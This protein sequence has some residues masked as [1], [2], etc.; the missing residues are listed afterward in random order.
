M[1]AECKAGTVSILNHVPS[2]RLRERSISMKKA[3]RNVLLG[4]SIAAIAAEAEAQSHNFVIP[5]VETASSGYELDGKLTDKVWEKAALISDFVPAGFSGKTPPASPVKNRTSVKVFYDVDAIYLGFTCFDRNIG[6]IIPG[7]PAGQTVDVPIAGNDD[8]LEILLFQ[9]GSDKKYYHLRIVP[10]GAK[11]DALNLLLE[12]GKFQRDNT[13]NGNWQVRTSKDDKA[14]YAEVKIPFEMFAQSEEGFLSATPVKGD[15]MKMNL[16]RVC[17]TSAEV[18]TWIPGPHGFHSKFA[19]CEFAGMPYGDIRVEQE[20][21]QR[22]KN[23]RNIYRF[24]VENTASR[25]ARLRITANLTEDELDPEKRREMLRKRSWQRPVR[26]TKVL[27]RIFD[28]GAGAKIP[29]TLEFDLLQGGKKTLDI[30]IDWLR[31]KHNICRA[32]AVSTIYDIREGLKKNTEKM[33]SLEA[34]LKD[35]S[36]KHLKIDTDVAKQ[37]LEAGNLL[38]RASRANES[39]ESAV[40][41]LRRAEALLKAIDFQISTRVRP[42]L[43]NLAQG[44]GNALF[45]IGT[46][47][48]G[49]KVFRDLPF[50]GK[51]T[52]GV[53]LNLAGNEYE[54]A[55]FVIFYLQG[56]KEKIKV[57]CSVL[58]NDSG[59]VIRRDQITFNPVG[60]VNIGDSGHHT[61]IGYWP[62]VLYQGNE[63]SPPQKGNVQPLMLTVKTDS[64]QAPGLYQGKVLFDNGRDVHEMKLNVRVY[65]FSLPDAKSLGMNIWFHGTRIQTFYG[66]FTPAR[67]G[68]IMSVMGRYHIAAG[69]RDNR[70]RA[71]LRVRK[72]NG[73]YEFDFSRMTPYYDAAVKNHANVLN[74][75]Y[76]D[77]EYFRTPR[78]ILIDQNGKLTDFLPEDPLSA[79]N[80]LFRQTIAYFKEKGYYKYAVLQVSDEPWSREKQEYIR[81]TVSRF[82]KLEKELPPIISAGAVRNRSNLN[83]Y[84]TAWCPQFPQF[85]PSDYRDMPKNE[86]LYFYQ[87]LYKPDFPMFMID[88]PGIEPRIASLICWKYQA[89]GFLYWASEQWIAGPPSTPENRKKLANR[90][91][92]EE[93]GFPFQNAPGD[94]CFIYPQKEGVIASLR[95]QYIRDGVEDYEYLCILKQYRDLALRKGVMNQELRRNVEALLKVPDHIVQATNVWTHSLSELENFRS[96]VAE[97]IMKLKELTEDSPQ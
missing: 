45:A 57:S 81:N 78:K 3:L 96:Q 10:S 21:V 42:G 53:S 55:Q 89:R 61:H 37:L 18:T 48:A 30:N 79:A 50:K 32:Y 38:K 83:G 47:D 19:S 60:Y 25:P 17:S 73:C 94:A 13:W 24:S 74:L 31:M 44:R 51:F 69:I 4:V 76:L 77:P 90:W 84:I 64:G 72:K 70:F 92:H 35:A 6:K 2:K 40:E 1:V 58:K 15:R 71:L 29:V 20:K 66:D 39:P 28:A 43:W 34:V 67:F 54:S 16:G 63:I 14:W 68:Q 87:C 95:A 59:A 56:K 5:R 65:P 82:R 75:E 91:I 23:G 9:P 41:A 93:W 52:D 49:E 46:A 11:E 12:P 80:Q 36:S 27:D 26:T 85:N 62:D 7:L 86:S 8:C 88:R 97:Q 22:L 33:T